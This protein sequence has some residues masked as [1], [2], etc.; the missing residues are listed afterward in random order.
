MTST[1]KIV[2]LVLSSFS[3]SLQQEIT[4]NASGYFPFYV[5]IMKSQIFNC[6]GI[7]IHQQWILV[8]NQCSKNLEINNSIKAKSLHFVVFVPKQRSFLSLLGSPAVNLKQNKLIGIAN[9]LQRKN[10]KLCFEANF[11]DISQAQNW[12]NSVIDYSINVGGTTES[13]LTRF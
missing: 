5:A 3:Q 8:A 11:F 1:L 13:E 12:I 7:L 2:I 9:D 10:C 6:P 4:Y